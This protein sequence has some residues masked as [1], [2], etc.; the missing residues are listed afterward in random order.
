MHLKELNLSKKGQVG[1]IRGVLFGFIALI[2]LSA[3]L[4]TISGYISDLVTGALAGDVMAIAL[5]SIIPLVII[6]SIIIGVLMGGKNDNMV[7]YQ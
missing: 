1:I 2:M 7:Y 3:F 6:I 4:P 5:V